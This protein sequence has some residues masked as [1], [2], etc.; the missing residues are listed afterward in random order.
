[1]HIAQRRSRQ[2]SSGQKIEVLRKS[3]GDSG[4]IV[5]TMEFSD[6]E[7]FHTSCGPLSFTFMNSISSVN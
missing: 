7:A 5:K 6:I 1:M 2:T 4:S 3:A